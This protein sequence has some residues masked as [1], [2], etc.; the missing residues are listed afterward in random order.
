MEGGGDGERGEEIYVTQDKTENSKQI[1]GTG[2]AMKAKGDRICAKS[3]KLRERDRFPDFP[4]YN[5]FLY[6]DDEEE[7]DDDDDD[8]DDL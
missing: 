5:E 3:R 7:E 6:F 2:D 1:S 8:D 4:F